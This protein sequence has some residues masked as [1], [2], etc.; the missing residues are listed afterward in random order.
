MYRGTTPY[1]EIKTDQDLS[2]MDYVVFTMEDSSG[3]EV[4]VDN[5]SGMMT[6]TSNKVTVKLT[7][8]QTLSLV[9][10]D[11]QIQLRA[12]NSDG[13]GAAAS[14]IMYGILNEIL[15]DGVIPT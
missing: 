2:K 9:E 8:D 5:Q 4:N 11:V 15:K 1:I 7:Q 14:N 13:S 6:I 12:S 10:G 3:T